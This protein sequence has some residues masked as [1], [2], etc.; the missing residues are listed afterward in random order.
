MP[1][2]FSNEN[3]WFNLFSLSLPPSSLTHTESCFFFG[4]VFHIFISFVHLF[5]MLLP[6]EKKCLKMSFVG[7]TETETKKNLNF[8]FFFVEKNSTSFYMRIMMMMRNCI[9]LVVGLVDENE[10]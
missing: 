7:Q 6:C 3:I 5:W 10:K 1:V 8:K 9:C 2:E 4:K